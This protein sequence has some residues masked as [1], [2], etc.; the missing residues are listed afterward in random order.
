M[1]RRGSEKAV[2][3]FQTGWMK[4]EE[5]TRGE[6][7]GS[8]NSDKNIKC[9]L[10]LSLK[11][12]TEGSLLSEEGETGGLFP[13]ER[14][15]QIAQTCF[16]PPFF[17]KW[18]QMEAARRCEQVEVDGPLF[19]RVC[20]CL[21]A[22][23]GSQRIYYTAHGSHSGA[24]KGG[25]TRRPGVRRLSQI[26]LI[27]LFWIQD[28]LDLKRNSCSVT[29]LCRSLEQ[30]A[31][32]DSGSWGED[33]GSSAEINERWGRRWRFGSAAVRCQTPDLRVEGPFLS[34]K[35]GGFWFQSGSIMF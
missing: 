3:V 17:Q 14:T 5:I 21:S 23:A 31:T 19:P 18:Q 22:H 15:C 11:A 29:Y 34:W 7:K 25:A 4:A 9:P 13:F 32:S 16:Q 30:S 1:K 35:A 33:A 20:R 26:L 6:G 12:T 28:W 10:I 27:S 8:W 24:L 2:C